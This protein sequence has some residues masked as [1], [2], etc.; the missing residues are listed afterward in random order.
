MCGVQW[1][2]RHFPERVLRQYRYVQSVPRHPTDVVQLTLP[3][4]VQ[5]FIDFNTCTLKD[6]D[7]GEPTQERTADG[8]WLCVMVH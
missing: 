3:Q 6:P 2:Y 5:T 1:V 8:G 4:I 7:W